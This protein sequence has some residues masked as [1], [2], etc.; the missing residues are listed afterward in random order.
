LRVVKT[1]L[2]VPEFID[3]FTANCEMDLN[4]SPQKASS[5]MRLF[6][7]FKS[8]KHTHLPYVLFRDIVINEERI[9]KALKKK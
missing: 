9:I 1:L 7:E 6:E 4:I 3:D 5:L 8:S 2:V